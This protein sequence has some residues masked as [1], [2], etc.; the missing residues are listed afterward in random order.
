MPPITFKKHATKVVI[1]PNGNRR[2][3]ARSLIDFV[4]I[5]SNLNPAQREAL[6]KAKELLNDK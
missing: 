3:S 6:N 5:G 2:K 4:L 1:Y